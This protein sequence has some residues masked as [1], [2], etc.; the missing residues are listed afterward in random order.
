MSNDIFDV[1]NLK[2]ESDK[3]A[4]KGFIEE[5]VLRKQKIKMENEGLKDIRNEC[6]DRLNI[7]PSTF[8]KV[9]KIVMNADMNKERNEFDNIETIIET[10]YP[11]IAGDDD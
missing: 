6:R 8:N 1:I 5:A 10:I 11:T 3:L 9:V 4:M 7:T 2:S